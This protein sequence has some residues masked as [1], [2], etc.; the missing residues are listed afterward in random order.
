MRGRELRASCTRAGASLTLPRG[1]SGQTQ[2]TEAQAGAL[3][4]LELTLHW[5]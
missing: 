2:T 4:A 3:S 5:C 1:A